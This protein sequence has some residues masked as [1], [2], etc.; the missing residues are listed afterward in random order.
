MSAEIIYKKKRLDLFFFEVRRID[1]FE[2]LSDIKLMEID[3]TI[4]QE[5]IKLLKLFKKKSFQLLFNDDE[6]HFHNVH[7]YKIEIVS[8]WAFRFRVTFGYKTITRV[9]YEADLYDYL[10]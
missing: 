2:P 7:L 10:E 6:Y 5:D 3:F 1:S 9:V 4:R 8:E